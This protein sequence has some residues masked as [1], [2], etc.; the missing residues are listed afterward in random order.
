[1]AWQYITGSTQIATQRSLVSRVNVTAGATG[2][3]C[4][5]IMDS[6]TGRD[7]TNIVM[8]VWAGA[9]G[10]ETKEHIP[11]G[12]GAQVENGIYAELN[13]TGANATVYW[14]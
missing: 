12:V 13:G 6:A 14:R 7:P 2:A 8:T 9:N 1:M 11:H 3:G 10:I 5:H 4:L